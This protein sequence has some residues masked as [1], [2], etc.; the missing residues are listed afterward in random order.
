MIRYC[1]YT[2]L[3]LLLTISL[4]VV[5]KT[6][7]IEKEINWKHPVLD[8]FKKHG[9]SLSKIRYFGDNTCPIFYVDFNTSSK[10]NNMNSAY[11]DILKA[12]FN[13]PYALIDKKKK[14]MINVGW[15]DEKP[16]KITVNSSAIYSYPNCEEGSRTMSFKFNINP[17]LKKA[18]LSS[19]YKAI[20]NDKNGRTFIAYLY[21]EDGITEADEYV[22][23][24]GETKATTRISG[25]FY[26]Y[27]YDPI[28]DTF[29]H[30][31]IAPFYSLQGFSM[32]KGRS[33]F[34]VLHHGKKNQSDILLIG[35]FVNGNGNQYEA[36]G[37]SDGIYPLKKYQF[38]KKEKKSFAF[39]G[40]ISA[41]KNS[42][43]AYNKHE[44]I[45]EDEKMRGIIEQFI[46]EISDEPD[47]IRVKPLAPGQ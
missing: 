15:S 22:T 8:V 5:S 6:I 35:V 26:I 30:Y 11:E 12:N 23:P 13:F 28:K 7:I 10:K 17:H 25:H 43:Y 14:L 47:E 24:D 18:I 44:N 33:D 9:I 32:L 19:S 3:L 29:L 41:T 38:V 37:F 21:A 42:I 39:Y 27:L 2:I 40:R 20:I 4:K 34:T 1:K 36:Y 45:D 16:S 46:F 31:K